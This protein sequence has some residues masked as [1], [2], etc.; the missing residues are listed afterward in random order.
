MTGKAFITATFNNTLVTITDMAGNAIAWGSAGAAG[1]KGARRATPYA[2]TTAVEVV[3]R[4]AMTAG[5]KEVEVYLK[6]PG[7]GRDAALRALKAAGLKMNL[8]ADVTP[9]PHNGVRPSKKR[10]V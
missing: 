9:V 4:K 5:I 10:R 2:A 6:G 3:A 7:S 1:F 8:I